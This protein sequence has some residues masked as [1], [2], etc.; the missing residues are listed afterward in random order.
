MLIHLS[1][2]SQWSAAGSLA[3]RLSERASAKRAEKGIFSAGRVASQ[4][5]G[6][7]GGKTGARTRLT[8]TA[9]RV[10]R[11]LPAGRRGCRLS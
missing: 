11:P 3:L 2:V 4:S 8:A 6:R 10:D 7:A 1:Q 5:Q 9:C